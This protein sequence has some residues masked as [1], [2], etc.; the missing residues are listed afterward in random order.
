MVLTILSIFFALVLTSFSNTA[1][2]SAGIVLFII[3][4][5]RYYKLANGANRIVS[6]N[7]T[8]LIF[9]FL[10]IISYLRNNNPH[11]VLISTIPN[12][13]VFML[14]TSVFLLLGK[15]YISK[16]FT[17]SPKF[18]VNFVVIPY[19]LFA[20]TNFILYY[21][22]IKV[23]EK[24]LEEGDT[25]GA[26]MLSYFG[27]SLQRVIFPLVNALN[28][29]S[30]YIGSI[31]GLSLWLSIVYKKQKFLLLFTTFVTL[32]VLL[33]VDSRA[34]LL[35]PVFFVI[36]SYIIYKFN[37]KRIKLLF[38]FLAF[39][40]IL[41]PILL[42]NLLPAI[43][44]NSAVSTALSRHTNDIATGNTR[45]AIWSMATETFKNFDPIQIVGY[46]Q[47][48]HYG[49]GAS[50]RWQYLFNGWK[51]SDMKSPHDTAL[52]VLFDIGY[53]GLIIYILLIYQSLK[54]VS[55]IWASKPIVAGALFI[56]LLYNIVEGIGESL[57]NFDLLNYLYLFIMIVII[58]NFEYDSLKNRK[59]Y[60]I[61]QQNE[62]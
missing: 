2:Q 7:K 13:V 30:I 15:Y 62:V 48:G 20:L 36:I 61:T 4:L 14:F 12:L 41:G 21:L 45:F 3:A 8:L 9:I 26:V 43:S 44:G 37:F 38:P 31:F 51:Y 58:I 16:E 32:A 19:L 27:I 33:F 22:K 59:Y 28:E 57:G 56:F 39:L 46:G 49:S 42:V 6:A 40:V 11:L 54:K 17:D 53:V 24:I 23:T 5:L 34:A 60:I 35:Y 47:T 52:S 10:L 1:M 29:Y 55:V 18:I 50:L 25:G